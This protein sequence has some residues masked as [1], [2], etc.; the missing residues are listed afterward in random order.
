MI[1]IKELNAIRRGPGWQLEVVMDFDVIPGVPETIRVPIPINWIG[2][3][4]NISDVLDD[5]EARVERAI[6]ALRTD[7]E[8]VLKQLKTEFFTKRKKGLEK[9]IDKQHPRL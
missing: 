2:A 8:P 7:I 1:E 3:K 6:H 9:K 4:N 5:I